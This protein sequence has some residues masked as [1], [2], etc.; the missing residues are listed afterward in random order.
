MRSRCGGNK[1]PGVRHSRP[2]DRA[3]A[4]LRAGWEI[5]DVDTRRRSRVEGANA[6][7]PPC[8][9]ERIPATMSDATD[10]LKKLGHAARAVATNDGPGQIM[11][12][13]LQVP[14]SLPVANAVQVVGI[15][16][17]HTQQRLGTGWSTIR[18]LRHA[19]VSAEA[20]D[21]LEHVL[22]QANNGG[23]GAPLLGAENG[24]PDQGCALKRGRGPSNYDLLSR[25]RFRN[26]RSRL[27]SSSPLGTAVGIAWIA[28]GTACP[29]GMKQTANTVHSPP[30]SAQWMR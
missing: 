12:R 21:Y 26:Q 5:V 24:A 16:G 25:S 4:V 13:L 6:A 15:R 7:D 2:V 9:V 28:S 8:G 29:S 11:K 30:G 19:I 17:V 27:S 18:K 10:I 20:R 3:L 23:K 14:R 22:H 1:D